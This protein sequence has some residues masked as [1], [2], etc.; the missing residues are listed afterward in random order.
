VREAYLGLNLNS[1]THLQ[2]VYLKVHESTS[3][4]EASLAV[5]KLFTASNCDK[6]CC[7]M[8]PKSVRAVLC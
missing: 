1:R 7:S 6:L 5:S 4:L 2:R 3:G 8:A